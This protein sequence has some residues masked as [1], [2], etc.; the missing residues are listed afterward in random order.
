MKERLEFDNSK[1]MDEVIRKAQ[2]CY[3]QNKPKGDLSKRW[4]KEKG[5]KFVPSYKGN[6]GTS[7]KGVF[8]GKTNQ[9]LN[10]NQP[11]FNVPGETKMNE[12]A[13]RTEVETTNRPPIECWGCR[14]PHYVKNYPR[15]RGDDQIS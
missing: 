3:H 11:R 4:A 14:G 6:K 15:R 8:K 10:R 12:Q 1:T 5:S 9:N 13:G 2:I 7:N